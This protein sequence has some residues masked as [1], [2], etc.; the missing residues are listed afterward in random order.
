MPQKVPA[1]KLS[2][3]RASYDFHLSA[4]VSRSLG[5]ALEVNMS[6]AYILNALP[7]AMQG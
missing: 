2:D 1:M 7:Y 6:A 3:S 5:R 4:L